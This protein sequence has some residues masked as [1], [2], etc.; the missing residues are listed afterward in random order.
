MI[1]S[2]RR[3]WGRWEE[4]LNEPGYRVKRLVLDP[5]KRISLQ[6]HQKRSE[7]WV[8]VSGEG[9]ATV[10]GGETTVRTGDTVFVPRQGIHRLSNVGESDLIVIETQIGECLEEDI[11]RFADDFGR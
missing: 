7:H 11:A 9:L 4:Y 5:G 3:P 8:V 10:D 6:S 1:S 2:D